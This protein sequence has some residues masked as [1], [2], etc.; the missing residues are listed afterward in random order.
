MYIKS[1]GRLDLAIL[2]RTSLHFLQ[3]LNFDTALYCVQLKLW[4][5][6][7]SSILLKR[8]NSSDTRVQQYLKY[9]PQIFLWLL[10]IIFLCCCSRSSDGIFLSKAFWHSLVDI[11]DLFSLKGFISVQECTQD[12]C[13]FFP[14][15]SWLSD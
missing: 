11:E 3:N 12:F 13:P 14:T 10:V 5:N 4:L 8:L 15:F 7:N 2:V 9:Y 6:G 1:P